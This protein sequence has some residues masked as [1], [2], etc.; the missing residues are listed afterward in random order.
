MSLQKLSLSTHI[1]DTSRGKP[2]S[3]V[4]VCFVFS[5]QKLNWI[6]LPAHWSLV[7]Q[8][9]LFKQVN[10]DWI[11]QSNFTTNVD[12]RISEFNI[13]SSE[14]KLGNFKLRFEV[15]AYFHSLHQDTLYPFIEVIWQY[16][17]KC[18]LFLRRFQITGI[19]AC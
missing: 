11:Q 17:Q 9:S 7:L 1:L 15:S 4:D 10:N 19:F 13:R 5:T 16:Y 12:G 2:S 8:V 14:P 18:S 3:N 6:K